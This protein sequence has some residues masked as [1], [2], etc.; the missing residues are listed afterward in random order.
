MT[1]HF[2]GDLMMIMQRPILAPV[3]SG[4]V[5]DARG[6]HCCDDK[7]GCE[8]RQS[9]IHARLILFSKHEKQTVELVQIYRLIF[10]AYNYM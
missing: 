8:C 4:Q 6:F 9:I 7:H 5:D 2:R 3:V 1:I 10:N